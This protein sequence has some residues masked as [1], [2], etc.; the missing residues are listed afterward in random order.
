HMFAAD[1]VPLSRPLWFFLVLFC[2][3]S[4]CLEWPGKTESARRPPSSSS[5]SSYGERQEGTWRIC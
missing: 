2:S 4:L 1:L 3:V 5:S